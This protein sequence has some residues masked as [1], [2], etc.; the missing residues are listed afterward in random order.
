[1]F[2]P[3]SRLREKGGGEGRRIHEV[4]RINLRARFIPAIRR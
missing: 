3:L 4:N 2:S 1:M